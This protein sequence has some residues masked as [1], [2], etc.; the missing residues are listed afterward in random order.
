[1]LITPDDDGPEIE[2]DWRLPR[3]CWGRGF[4]TEAAK[5]ILNYGFMGLRLE[6]IVAVID[7]ENIRSKVVASRIGL[8]PAGQQRAYGLDLD[9]YV[10]TADEFRSPSGP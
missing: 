1:M 6:Q 3:A 7:R 9:L 8:R 4:A 5:T 10:P 2:I